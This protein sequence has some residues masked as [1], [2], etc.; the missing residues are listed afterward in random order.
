M[1]LQSSA[2][3]NNNGRDKAYARIPHIAH[4]NINE[5]QPVTV[6]KLLIIENNTNIMINPTQSRITVGKNIE[7]FCFSMYAEYAGG[8]DSGFRN[9]LVSGHEKVRFRGA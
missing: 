3:L 2:L 6:I 4:M 1:S 8:W 9:V 5:L 7:S